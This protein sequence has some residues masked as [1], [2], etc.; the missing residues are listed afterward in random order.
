MREMYRKTTGAVAIQWYCFSMAV[1]VDDSRIEWR[2]KR[3]SHL[4]A[5]SLEELHA[6]AA[7][8]GLKREW[9]QT[10]PGRPELDHYDVTESKRLQAIEMGAVA[11]TWREGAGRLRRQLVR[12]REQRL[13]RDQG[14]SGAPKAERPKLDI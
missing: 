2:G 14:V 5:D 3:W 8:L 7:R 4:Q 1:Y 13:S 12:Q 10:K 9:F 6:F 11:E